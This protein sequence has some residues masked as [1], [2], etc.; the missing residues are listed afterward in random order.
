MSDFKE[1][2]TQEEFDNA[3]KERLERERAK[4]GDYEDLKKKN[5]EYST[6]I[7][8][9]NKQISESASKYKDTDKTI[10]EL[11]SRIKAYESD[12]VKTRIALQKGLP[13]EFASRLQGET[14][15]DILKDA[16]SIASFIGKGNPEPTSTIGEGNQSSNNQAWAE[17]LSKIN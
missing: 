8:S 11:N 15:E 14:E 3:I 16:E 13:Y 12:S 7:E 10:A 2:K 6:Q 5:Q 1:I 9:L 4:F 17:L